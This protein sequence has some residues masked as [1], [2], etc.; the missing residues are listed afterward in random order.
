M[1]KDRIISIG[2]IIVTLVVTMLLYGTEY[3]YSNNNS[4]LSFAIETLATSTESSFLS[5]PPDFKAEVFKTEKSTGNNLVA[6]F[7]SKDNPEY[8]GEAVFKRGLNFKYRIK[9]VNYNFG[10]IGK[11]ELFIFDILCLIVIVAGLGIA[12]RFWKKSISVAKH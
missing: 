7:T 2:C 9:S 6:Y 4:D 5:I 12:R 1:N 8:I 11:A 10:G 3:S